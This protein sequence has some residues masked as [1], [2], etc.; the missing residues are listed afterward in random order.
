MKEGELDERPEQIEAYLVER[1][2]AFLN[3]FL[4]AVVWKEIV[5]QDLDPGMAHLCGDCATQRLLQNDLELKSAVE[6]VVIDDDDVE[7]PRI[8]ARLEVHALMLGP[9]LHTCL[10]GTVHRPKHHGAHPSEGADAYYLDGDLALLLPGKEQWRGELHGV[11]RLGLLCSFPCASKRFR[12]LLKRNWGHLCLLLAS[13]A[14]RRP[15]LKQRQ[16]FLHTHQ[17]CRVGAHRGLV[18]WR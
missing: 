5:V 8:F 1:I 11:R 6:G 2:F 14:E 18:Q 12:G 15:G 9:I 7:A 4:E 3:V 13:H 16:V 17:P 10:C